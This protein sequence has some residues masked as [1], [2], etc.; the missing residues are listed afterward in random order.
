MFRLSLAFFA[1]A[2]LLAALGLLTAGPLAGWLA[3][4]SAAVS[5]L[6]LIAGLRRLS[7]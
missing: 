6:F 3:T 5:S 4:L 2:V 1:A 7:A